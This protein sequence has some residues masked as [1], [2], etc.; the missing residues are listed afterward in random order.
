MPGVSILELMY[1]K[2]EKTERIEEALSTFASA[3]GLGKHPYAFHLT[4][5]EFLICAESGRGSRCVIAEVT[6]RPIGWVVDAWA[7]FV[8][9]YHP[10]LEKYVKEAA[11]KEVY[12]VREREDS[13]RVFVLHPIGREEDTGPYGPVIEYW[14]VIKSDAFAWR[15]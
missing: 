14:F 12:V 7:G 8:K 9:P 2:A 11:E 13:V 1:R 15:L 4:L 6:W 10:A 3:I 5:N